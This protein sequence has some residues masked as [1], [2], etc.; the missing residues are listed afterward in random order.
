MPAADSARSAMNTNDL[1]GKI[2]RIKVKDGDITPAEANTALGGAYTIPAGNLFPLV[3]GQPQPK[4]KPEVYAMGFRNP[5]RHPG[6][7]ERRRVRQR[8]LARL[9]GAA[10][11]PRRS[12]T[13]RF[14]I[15]RHPANYGWPYCFK[16][17][18]PEYPWNVNLQ[19]PMNLINHQPVP[20][21]QTPQPYQC[22]AATM[23]NNDYWNVNGGP[24]VEPGLT[25]RPGPHRAGHL[26]LV[27][28]QPARQPAGDAVLRRPTARTLWPTRPFPGRRRS[29]RACSPSSSRTAWARTGSRSTSTTRT[30]RTR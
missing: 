1:R 9:A 14:E 2:L 15:V 29:V 10:A 4:T 21:G 6:R 28:R 17:D 20:A 23:P 25:T 5:F 3:G 30:T 26:V 27:R 24:S 18:L 7:R 13:G 22:D 12:G 16:P 8:L 19:V 11:V